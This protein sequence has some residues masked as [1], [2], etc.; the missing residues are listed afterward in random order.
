MCHLTYSLVYIFFL[1]YIFFK[2]LVENVP[3][4]HT[5]IPHLR[6]MGFVIS[7]HFLLIENGEVKCGSFLLLPTAAVTLYLPPHPTG[8]PRWC[9]GKES[10]CPSRR[11]GFDPWVRKFPWRRKWQPTSVFLPENS[12]VQRSLANCSAWGHRVRHN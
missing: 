9:S 5:C 10:A 6:M 4:Y 2:L 3:P 8:L 11:H 12:H 7:H 1:I